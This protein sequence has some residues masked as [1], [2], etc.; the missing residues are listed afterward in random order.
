MLKRAA[1]A[2]RRL[3][4]LNRP[5]ASMPTQGTLIN[6][7]GLQEA[8]DS[9]AIENIVTPCDELFRTATDQGLFASAAAKAVRHCVQALRVGFGLVRQMGRLT[10]TKYLDALAGAGFVQ[11]VK[12][13][14]SN[15]YVNQALN[16]I[17]TRDDTAREG[18]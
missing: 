9:A 15:Y 8:K 14:R 12:V 16:S 17:L 10:A 1:T 4:E 2:G 5:A 11:K 6:T 18:A 3:A 7:L 13:G